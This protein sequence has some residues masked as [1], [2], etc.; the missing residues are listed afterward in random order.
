MCG[1]VVAY[2]MPTEEDTGYEV[3]KSA[4][5]KITDTLTRIATQPIIEY[6]GSVVKRTSA[7]I[8]EVHQQLVDQGFEATS[9]ILDG[10]VHYHENESGI[11]LTLVETRR[12]T[13]VFPAGPI[14]GSLFGDNAVDITV[15]R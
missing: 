6:E 7:P 11:N 1:E 10:K 12:G 15:N 8:D 14:R 2:S 3:M 13:L 4:R 5:S 9:H